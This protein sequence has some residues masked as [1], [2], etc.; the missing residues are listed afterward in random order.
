[1]PS[2]EMHDYH[3]LVYNNNYGVLGI[4]DYIHGTDVN[5]RKSTQYARHY[6]F[7]RPDIDITTMNNGVTAQ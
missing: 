1:M 4:L 6:T 3:H 5:Y 2:P 7:L